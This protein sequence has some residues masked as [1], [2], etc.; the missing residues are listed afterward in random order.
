MVGLRR[1]GNDT[2]LRGLQRHG[3]GTQRSSANLPINRKADPRRDP[4]ERPK[5][6]GAND[7]QGA[8]AQPF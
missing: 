5:G 7:F 3:I 2:P 1:S 6:T 4:A 8:N